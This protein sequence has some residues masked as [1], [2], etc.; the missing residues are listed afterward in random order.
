MPDDDWPTLGSGPASHRVATRVVS[1]R[2]RTRE[3]EET[4]KRAELITQ[5][6]KELAMEI[7][8]SELV[9]EEEQEQKVCLSDALEARHAYFRHMTVRSYNTA[10]ETSAGVIMERRQ[11][12]GR[13]PHVL[14]LLK[15]KSGFVLS[16]VPRLLEF[17][18][19]SGIGTIDFEELMHAYNERYGISSRDSEYYEMLCYGFY[20]GHSPISDTDALRYERIVINWKPL[21]RIA[22]N[23][24]HSVRG[25]LGVD[26]YVCEAKL[27]QQDAIDAAK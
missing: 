9:A 19:Y 3:E 13:R 20:S 21:D 15:K 4:R 26:Q 18:R 25:F 23:K 11:I 27:A 12:K 8:Q 24:T 17:L 14:P 16:P 10:A 1:E 6:H 5:R 22:F 7:R 2:Q